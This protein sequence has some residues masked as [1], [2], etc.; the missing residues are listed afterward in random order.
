MD[1]KVFLNK[2]EGLGIDHYFGV[3]DSQL[4]VLIDE[5]YCRHGVGGR[6]IVA[7]NEGGAVALA[8]G[9][10]LA[11][12]KPS[13]IYMQNSGIGNAANPV[14]S[15]M[16][17][18]VYAIPF[19]MAV[20]WRGEPGIKDEPQHVFQGEI[21]I[22]MLELMDIACFIL[23]PETTEQEL[24][25]Y[26]QKTA[27][28][29]Y[30]GKGSAFIVKKGAFKSG[31]KA[32]YGNEACMS[33]E[34]AIQVI[35]ECAG[36]ADMF[37]ST[38]GKASRELFE[39]REAN[40]EGHERDFLT[41]GSMGHAIMIALGAAMAKPEKTFW[42]I[43]GDGA[44]V[45]HMG[46]ALIA[47]NAGCDNL[48]HIVLNNGAHETVGGLP[49]AEG[50]TDYCKIA[51]ALGYDNC[52]RADDEESLRDCM[53]KIKT[54]KGSKFIEVMVALGA[55]DDLGRPTTTPIQNKNAFMQFL[56]GDIE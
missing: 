12:G 3:P 39:A 10:Y 47:V 28:R 16:N 30:A 56:N 38:T 11:T 14:I 24:D 13:L 50:N 54:A 34:R 6:H 31:Q 40:G 45:M 32:R 1:V 19:V 18:K 51:Q 35:N 44:M 2:L 5:I 43:D 8:A 49:V 26:I 42:C 20:G 53:E 41:V 17:D 37:V 15:L 4:K 22:Q 48:I 23:T 33:R 21:T 25:G 46:S 7:A 36:S 55:R 9:R 27:E 29:I 52:L